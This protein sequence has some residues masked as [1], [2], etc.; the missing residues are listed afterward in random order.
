MRK[1]KI[2][3]KP[4]NTRRD[5]IRHAGAA[6]SMPILVSA[7]A[8]GEQNPE[9]PA[10][11]GGSPTR[12]EPFPS[13]PQAE[14]IDQD[15]F[16]DS[17]RRMEWC[18]L[19]GDIT[20]TFETTWAEKLGAKYCTGV[21]NGT[22]ALYAALFALDV[23]PGDEVLVPP[24]TFV[25]TVNA[26]L[27]QYALP[28]FVDSDRETMQ[29]DTTKLED[30]ITDHTRCIMPVHLGGSMANMDN[31]LAVAKKHSLSVVEDAC[32]AHFAEWHGKKSG[33]LGDI[34]CFSFQSTKILPCGEGGAIVSSNEE[35]LDKFH[36]FQN[37]GRDRKTG[38]RHGYQYQGGNLRMTEF[39]GAVLLGQLNRFE[40]ICRHR[41]ENADY[42]TKLLED[43]PGISRAKM[44]EGCNR[45]TYYI[46][47]M[48]YD[49]EQF[50]GLPRD[51]FTNAMNKEGI[52]IGSGYSRPLNQ[53][54]FIEKMLSSN[55]Y[56]RIYSKERLNRYREMNHCPEN[57]KL[58]NE[59][60]FMSQTYLLGT[61]QD[62]EQIAEAI[63]K[64]RAY[65]HKLIKT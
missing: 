14:K 17:F 38:T 29:M 10:L 23:G 63:R 47:M 62:V 8:L 65:A 2:M 59:G 56:K 39:Q 52:P 61:R 64:I 7:R 13:W 40:E 26:V 32:Q 1:E 55:A 24:Y 50:G 58:C 5:F 16:A 60:L 41:E 15:L 3:N 11:L 4:K 45:N 33:T 30:R 21:V 28:V 27:Q 37:N 43:I 44:H 51:K 35:L 12:K 42:L 6:L 36:A 57:D 34:G 19:Y 49:Q 18:R 53:E 22:S 31:V 54:P 9:K 46:Y 25:A 48:K 20:T